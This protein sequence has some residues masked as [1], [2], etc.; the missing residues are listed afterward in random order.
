MAIGQLELAFRVAAGL[1]VILAP[2][3]LFLGLWKGLM[4]LRDENLIERV[5]RMEGRGSPSPATAAVTGSAAS[6][7]DRDEEPHVVCESCGTPN[8]AGMQICREC[9]GTLPDE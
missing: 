4:R 9:L 3:A 5:R 2:T 7:L 1:F 6:A 8:A